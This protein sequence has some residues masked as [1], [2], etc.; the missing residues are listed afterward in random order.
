MHVDPNRFLELT[1]KS[2]ATVD[3]GP[4]SVTIEHTTAQKVDA[5]SGHVFSVQNHTYERPTADSQEEI[6]ELAGIAAGSAE[7]RQKEMAVLSNSLS[8]E[9]YQ[10]YRENGGSLSDVESDEIVTVVDKIKIH[11]AESGADVGKITA[12]KEAIES[13]SNGRV[14][15]EQASAVLAA[16]DLPVTNDNVSDLKK[17]FELASSLTEF[18]DGAVKYMTDNQLPAEIE[19]LYRAENGAGTGFGLNEM[20]D[21]VAEEMRPQM[22]QMIVESG[23]PVTEDTLSNSRWMI[24]NE[25]PL[26]EENL[27]RV[28]TLKK[29]KLPFEKEQI[30]TAMTD[31]ITEGKR[32]QEAKMLDFV[33]AKRTLEETRLAMTE[34]ANRSLLKKGMEVD[35]TA[36]QETVEQLKEQERTFYERLLSESGQ[37]TD[38]VS[39]RALKETV[40]RIDEIRYLPAYTLSIPKADTDTLNGIREVGQKL[41]VK[42][43]QAGERYETMQTEIRRDLGDSIKKAFRNVDNLLQDLELPQTEA[44]ERAVRILS[45]NRIEVTADNVLAMKA[46]DEE[47]QRALKALTPSVVAHMVKNNQNPLDLNLT[48]LGNEAEALKKEFGIR[49]EDRFGEYLYKLEHNRQISE[50]ERESYVGIFRLIRQIEKTDGAA[51]GAVVH[52]GGELTMR[53]LLTAVR[54]SRKGAMD[55]RVDDDFGGV[56]SKSTGKD[57]LT[58]I[59]TAYED[60][61][62]QANVVRDIAEEMSPEA[63]RTLMKNDANWEEQTP[64]QFLDHLREADTADESAQFVRDQMEQ[65]AEAADTEQQVY[66]MMEQFDVPNSMANVL[67]VKQM[68]EYPNV[69]IRRLFGRPVENY[70]DENGEVD[71]QE[72]KNSL[73][74]EFGEAVSEPE[75]LAEAQKKLADVAENVMKT[76]LASEDTTTTELDVKS[77]KM[78]MNRF[79]IAGRMAEK[80]QYHI[81]V[82]VRGETGEVTLKIVSGTEKKGIVDIMFSLSSLG[83][84]A[85]KLKVEDG[86]VSGFVA[87]DRRETADLISE[88]GNDLLAAL[89]SVEGIRAVNVNPIHDDK[90]ELPKFSAATDTENDAYRKANGISTE[91]RT[92]TRV[93]YQIAKSFLTVL[94]SF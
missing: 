47:V 66:R 54:S 53:S 81:P 86:K 39:V 73:F 36:L 24:A 74:R 44:N 20:S 59:Q 26:N 5:V 92:P 60:G 17:A 41:K 78:A 52:Q 72:V 93:L 33:T 80:E 28:D 10:K 11:L 13:I 55:Y 68:M 34:D 61:A 30:L 63:F 23:L 67:A 19:N 8:A 88:R 48:E 35:T 12:G 56:A 15:T 7:A 16:A 21:A 43:D 18:S 6:R 49:E 14:T 45:Y 31:A 25:I 4:Y 64:E 42:M 58:Q 71:F 50:A 69:A 22:E 65:L 32:P 3:R 62:Y 90:L 94:S 1:Q 27:V 70:R 2:H 38:E 76:M 91:K 46:K 29:M 9:D 82:L 37:E 85:A 84:V 89:T 57:I 40:D 83:S 51:I 79:R 77:L 75:D 87:S